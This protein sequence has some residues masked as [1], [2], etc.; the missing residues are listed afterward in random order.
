MNKALSS[1]IEEN[2]I[3]GG[4][5]KVRFSILLIGVI[6]G[7]IVLNIISHRDYIQ[8]AFIDNPEVA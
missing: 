8:V 5:K 4:K 3:P 7:A 2:D 6:A 1:S